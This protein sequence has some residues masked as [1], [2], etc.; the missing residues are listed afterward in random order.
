MVYGCGEFGTF[1]TWVPGLREVMLLIYCSC[2]DFLLGLLTSP[3]QCRCREVYVFVIDL[4]VLYKVPL[5]HCRD[6]NMS[7]SIREAILSTH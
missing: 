4:T 3:A 1:P 7:I 2:F 6:V 5:Q